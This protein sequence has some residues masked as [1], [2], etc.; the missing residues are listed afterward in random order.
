[1]MPKKNYFFAQKRPKTGWKTLYTA[2]G[3]EILS[4]INVANVNEEDCTWYCCVAPRGKGYT[5]ATALVWSETLSANDNDVWGYGI[6][7]FPGTRIG[8]MSS[9]DSALTFSVYGLF[10]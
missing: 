5:K 2:L 4:Y 9:K 10:G 8:V 3:G 7:L 1:M 6:P